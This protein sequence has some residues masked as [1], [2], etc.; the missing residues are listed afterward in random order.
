MAERGRP[1]ALATTYDMAFLH[2][3]MAGLER[4]PLLRKPCTALPF[5]QV[6]VRELSPENARWL[7]ALNLLLIEAKMQD[8]VLDEKPW[9]GRLG[10]RVL[11]PQVAWARQV[12]GPLAGT[13]AEL[14]AR[15]TRAESKEHP[16]LESLALPFC[17]VLGQAFAQAGERCGRPELRGVLQHLGQ[18]VGIVVYL[19]DALD[20]LPQDRARGRFN[21][22]AACPGQGPQG[23][24]LRELA[25][26]ERALAHLGPEGRL[27]G[28]ILGRL[29]PEP[30]RPDPRL[31]QRPRGTC[32]LLLCCPDLLTCCAAAGSDGSCCWACCDP[33]L[34]CHCCSAAQ[35]ASSKSP[36]PTA[37]MPP[38]PPGLNCPACDR[39]LQVRS[40][41]GI[42]VDECRSGCR[43]IWLDH[44]E[45]G[46]LAMLYKPP[47]R[48]LKILPQF[49]DLKIRPE[50]TRPCPRC[51]EILVVNTVQGIRIDLCARCRGMWLDQGELNRLL[52]A[53]DHE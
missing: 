27:A 1:L 40:F 2:L 49:Q 11:R 16:T 9:K 51:G 30:A 18:A 53:A 32:D 34:H 4:A 47:E 44:G 31:R 13:L 42:E 25:R 22:V 38:P 35:D 33:C 17:R 20:D 50:G 52:E 36:A 28:E 24:L 10:L 29:A 21:A 14:P 8:D 12:L 19:R 37:P 43:G 6:P 48:L 45:L 23:V 26:A 46:R 15:Q 39:E 41:S 7:A 3:L 5:R